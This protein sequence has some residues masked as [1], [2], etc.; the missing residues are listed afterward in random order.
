VTGDEGAVFTMRSFAVTTN[1]GRPPS[2]EYA[3]FYAGYLALAPDEDMLTALES[4][5]ENVLALLGGV[6]EQTG[7]TVHP[8][9][10]WSVKQ[11]IGHLTDAERVF[12]HRAF[13]FGRNDPTPLPAFDENVYVDNAPFDAYRLTDLVAEFEWSRRGNLSMFRHLPPEAWQLWGVASDN[14]VTVRALA[15]IL[16]GHSRHHLAILQKRLAW[17]STV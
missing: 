4:Q 9:Y 8:P 12:G 3:P 10:T 13:R 2:A 6:S 17:T 11:V 15:Y 7:N 14:K 16:L 1:P 5:L